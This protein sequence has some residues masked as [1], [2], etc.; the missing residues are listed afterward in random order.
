MVSYDLCR[1]N[2]DSILNLLFPFPIK[3]TNRVYNSVG[4]VAIADEY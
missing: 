2:Q 3:I 4:I 1:I